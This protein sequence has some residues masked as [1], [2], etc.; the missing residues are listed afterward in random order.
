V[1]EI[2]RLSALSIEAGS[3]HLGKS[4]I[5]NSFELLGYDYMVD[6]QFRSVLIEVNSNP[7]LE[8]A[9]PM[10]ATLIPSLIENVVKKSLGVYLFTNMPINVTL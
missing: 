5:K 10:L 8:L 7:C 9:C 3:E 6:E 1:P 2:K 4:D